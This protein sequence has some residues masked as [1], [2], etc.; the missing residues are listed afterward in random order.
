MNKKSEGRVLLWLGR[1][2]GTEEL[3]NRSLTEAS[4]PY[5]RTQPGVSL[6]SQLSAVQCS[7]LPVLYISHHFL[8]YRL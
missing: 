5:V 7:V 6:P 8:A 2:P 1:Y 3:R 4:A